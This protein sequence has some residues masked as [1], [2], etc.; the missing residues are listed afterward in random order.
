MATKFTTSVNIIRD[1]DRE[2]N[3]TPTPNAVRVVNQIANDF[4]KGIRSFNI[5]GS[6]GTGK[7]AFL[8]AFQQSILGKKKYFGINLLPSPNIAFI[9]IVGEYK[10]IKEAFAETFEIKD[11]RNLSENIFSEIFNKYHDL[12]KKNTILFLVI[13]EFGKFLEYA[14]Q[15]EPEKELYFIQQLAEFANNPDINIVLF[16][17]VHQN[18]DAYA[19]SLSQAQKQEWTKVKG[20]FREITFNEPVEQLLFL[21]SEHLNKKPSANKSSKEITKSIDLLIKSKAFTVNED[22]I[23][24]VAEKLFPL[25]AISAYVLTLSLQKYGQNE[26]SLFSFLE[27]TDHTGLFQHSQSKEGFYTIADVYEYLIFNYYSFLNSRYNPDFAAWKSIKTALEKV[28]ASFEINVIAYTKIIKAI[29]LLNIAS[30]AGAILDKTFLVSY[31]E[32]C[33]GLK[34][35]SGLI[36]DL[37]KKKIILYR[38]YSKRFVLFEGTDL[39]IQM[40]LFEAGNKV[41]DVTDIATLL[42]KSYNVPPVVAKKIMYETGTPRL[43]EYKIS[44]HPTN[45][46]P[47]GEIDGFI[48]LI[49]NEKNI[50]NEIKEHSRNNEEAV[51][52]CYYKNSKSIKDLLFEI[53][54]TKK[55]ID[56]NRDDKVVVREL[57]SVIKHQ[58]NLLT[59]KILNNFSGTKSEVIWFFKGEQINI[60]NKKM[61][62]SRLSAICK[63]VYNNAPIFNNEL[64]NKHKISPSIHTAKRNYFKALVANWDKPQLGFAADKFPPEKTIYLS[65]LENNNINLY[66]DEITEDYKPNNKNK[67]DELWKLSMEFLDS[68]KTSRR[69]LAEFVETLSQKPFKLK[70][71]LID[72][73]LPTFLFIKR[74]D[75]AL[76]GEGGY[77]PFITDEVLDLVVKEPKDFE[78]KTFAI[79]GVKLNIFNS[80]RLFLNQNSKNKLSNTN[81]IETI[82]PFLTFYREL[83]E[84]SKNTKR[85]SKEAIEIRKAIASSKDP[86]KTFFED[87]PM[88]L[89][90]SINDIQDSSKSLQQYTLKLQDAIRNIRT[91]YDELVNRMELFIQSDIVG[92]TIPFEAYKE[93]LQGRYKKLRRHL[94]LPQQ[95]IFVQRIDS[96]IE[97]KKAWLNSL[98]QALINT[99]LDKIKDEEEILVYDKFKSMIVELDSLTTLSKTDFK[100]DKEDVFD[101]QINSFFDGINKKII[102]LPKSKKEEVNLIQVELKKK[103]SKDNSLNI[104]A[105]TNLLK[106][107]LKK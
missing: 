38:N 22:Y 49:F 25:D 81:F 68:A 44:A 78:I 86:E 21:A 77:I 57:N 29:G 12:G 83:P 87:F 84:Y 101:L 33:I 20:R 105:L 27:S 85:L 62:N 15:N 93:S 13:D 8:W 34:N 17:T 102:R 10:S 104:A 99:T 63:I 82:K 107:M 16:T 98:T 5:I 14:S 97:D 53:E 9:N 60:H 75:I 2:L 39:D 48:N 73:W 28:E 106:E 46:I 18:F 96:Q 4:K 36:E 32:K 66:A 47:V 91:C 64:V 61:F 92:E 69:T 45:D 72:F 100:E 89:G 50:T 54:K 51:L 76:F 103:L 31:A 55:V 40:A 79:E 30:Q 42:S 70:Q 94:L 52:Y 23:N 1:S 41:E 43:F 65:L 58:Q 26:R 90:Y 95:R 56:E 11:N 19:L 80:Y 37:E 71:G 88:A 3:Y 24:D 7:S 35:A 6:Y 74:D 67:F 59:Y